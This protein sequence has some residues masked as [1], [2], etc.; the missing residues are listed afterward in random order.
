LYKVVQTP[1]LLVQLTEDDAHYRQVFLDGRSHPIDLNPTWKGH[2]TGTWDGD[3]LVIDSVGFNDKTWLPGFLPHTERLH[4]IERY[5]RPD[6]GHLEIEVTY[7]DP[8]ALTTPLRVKHIWE[9]VP[10][11]ELQEWVCENNR[12]RE[13]AGGR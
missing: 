7:D 12:F 1:S 11:E 3:V 9:L 6:L 13:L 4:V 2:S 5:Q 10:G 8:G